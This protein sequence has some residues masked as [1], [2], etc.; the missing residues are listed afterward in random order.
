MP[1]GSRS[2]NYTNL[3]G[4]ADME[5]DMYMYQRNRDK[6]NSTENETLFSDRIE[7]LQKSLDKREEAH[8]ECEDPQR[9]IGWHLN[10][11]P[12]YGNAGICWLHKRLTYCVCVQKYLKKY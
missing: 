2:V 8:K 4:T 5:Y 11:K 3:L 10:G 9:H 1:V 12:G 6:G 7:M